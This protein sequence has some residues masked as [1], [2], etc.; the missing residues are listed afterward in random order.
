M[1]GAVAYLE[2]P[3]GRCAAATGEPVAAVL[4]RELDPELLEPVNRAL[5]VAGEDLDEAHVG[6]VVRALEDVGRVLLGRV[7]VAER[8]LDPP[9]ALAELQAWIEPFV[10]RPTRAPAR[11]ADTAA[12]SPEAPLP[13]TSTSKECEPVTSAGYRKR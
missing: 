1:P 6:A 2:Q 8:R 9:C 12:A 13:I 10:A 5:R 3:L 7:V 11:S 4:A